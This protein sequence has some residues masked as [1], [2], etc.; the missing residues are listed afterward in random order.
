MNNVL[1]GFIDSYEVNE[2]V[3]AEYSHAAGQAESVDRQNS[4]IPAFAG[5]M[6]V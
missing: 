5:T 3:R 6:L 1:P 2:E 4:S